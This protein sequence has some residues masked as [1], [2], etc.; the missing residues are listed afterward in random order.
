[1]KKVNNIFKIV[2]AGLFLQVIFA[3]PPSWDEITEPE[4]TQ[5]GVLD[6]YNDY[7]FNG[8]VTSK[9]Y[10]D[11]VEGG[12]L[13]DMVA[14]FVDGEQR[15]V[16]LAGE[17]PP[18]LGNGF[19]FLMMVYSNEASGGEMMSFQYYDESSNSVYNTNETLAFGV[20]MVE[21]DV[22]FPF[23]FTFSPGSGPSAK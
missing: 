18:F 11:G 3:D 13:G 4:E 23:E 6:N 21:G 5:L 10:P 1:M 16:G 20:N 9:I 7:E 2:C 12:A 14:A 8:S 15:G 22:E 19:A 17:V